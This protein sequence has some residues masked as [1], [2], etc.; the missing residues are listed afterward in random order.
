MDNLT[1]FLADEI[2]R[3]KYVPDCPSQSSVRYKA[4]GVEREARAV[5]ITHAGIK[6]E[7]SPHSW[8]AATAKIAVDEFAEK[9]RLFTVNRAWGYR[10]LPMV[11]EDEGRYVCTARVFIFER[12][13]TASE[14]ELISD[15]R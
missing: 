8:Y 9:M 12:A 14:V 11:D 2:G 6:P 7:G 3:K 13:D 10:R 1:Q 5:T 15:E 4:N